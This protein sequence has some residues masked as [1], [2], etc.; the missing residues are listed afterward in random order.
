M[1]S[2]CCRTS[3][4][5][6]TS[7]SEKQHTYLVLAHLLE[8][9]YH[10]VDSL[11]GA[12]FIPF[13]E[14]Y[15]IYSSAIIIGQ[16]ELCYTFEVTSTRFCD[17]YSTSAIACLTLTSMSM[18]YYL[19]H[20]QLAAVVSSS[21]SGVVLVILYDLNGDPLNHTTHTI[22]QRYPR[23]VDCTTYSSVSAQSQKRDETRT[24]TVA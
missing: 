12:V 22:D 10:P 11:L 7:T 5:L 24:S 17:I 21:L 1:R 4:S 6:A 15:G 3:A 8:V 13:Q 19:Y 20:L 16:D 18:E 23:D 9:R 2:R 14:I